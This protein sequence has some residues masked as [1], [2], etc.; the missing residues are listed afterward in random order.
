MKK[1]FPAVLLS[2]TVYLVAFLI[3]IYPSFITDPGV[4]CIAGCRQGKG[5]PYAFNFSHRGILLQG[6]AGVPN[7]IEVGRLLIDYVFVSILGA[8][9]LLYS[10]NKKKTAQL[11]AILYSIFTVVL[12]LLVGLPFLFFFVSTAMKRGATLQDIPFN[13]VKEPNLCI[14]DVKQCGDGTYVGRS[15]PNCE[16][17]KCSVEPSEVPKIVQT[18]YPM[19]TDLP[20][21]YLPKTSTQSNPPPDSTSTL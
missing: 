9:P 10:I 13:V 16:F 7:E 14:A 2:I 5:F 4:D 19:P 3:C 1:H 20:E 11:R 17:A 12:A 18:P 8:L 21:S 6:S 15:G